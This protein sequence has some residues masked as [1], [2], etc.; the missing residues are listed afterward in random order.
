[1]LQHSVFT[2]Y[3]WNMITYTLPKIKSFFFLGNIIKINNQ[4]SIKK[5]L[6]TKNNNCE[7]RKNIGKWDLLCSRKNYCSRQRGCPLLMIISDIS[8]VTPKTD[9]THLFAQCYVRRWENHYFYAN[10][11]YYQRISHVVQG[12]KKIYY[13]ESCKNN[14]LSQGQEKLLP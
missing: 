3:A 8:D 14:V 4:D 5:S 12:I 2:G 1:M 13:P 9:I 11:L 10:H 6:D 7:S